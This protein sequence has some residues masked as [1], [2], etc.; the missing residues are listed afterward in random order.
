MITRNGYHEVQADHLPDDSRRILPL[1]GNDEL[2]LCVDARGMMHDFDHI[3]GSHPPPRISWS[4]RRHDR[5]YDRYNSNLFEWGFV[6]L[7]LR[8][9]TELPAVT[10]WRQQLH[11]REGYVE[12][13]IQRGDVI[14]RTISFVHL[15]TNLIVFHREYKNLPEAVNRSMNAVYTLCHVGTDDLPFRVRWTPNEPFA[16]GISADT[17]ADGMWMYRGRATLFADTDATALNVG[18]RLELEFDLP[19]TNVVTV[20]LSLVDDLGDH[21][22]ILAIPHAG[23]M[24]DA[25][26]EVHADNQRRLDS[27]TPADYVQITRE[28]LAEFA[29]AGFQGVLQSHTQAWQQW[30][31]QVKL[32]LPPDEEELRAVLDTQLYTM[33][34][35]YTQWSSPANPFNTSWGAPYFWDERFPTEGLMRL[36]IM[37][38]PTRTAEWRRAILPFSTM[39]TGGR[40]ARYVPSAVEPGSQIADR[41]ATQYYEFFTIGV[42]VNYLYEYCRQ[43]DQEDIWRRYYPIFRESAEFFR[44]WLLIELPGNNI[45]LTWLVD[46][47]ET[48][49]PVQDGPF[50]TCGAARIFQVAA[51][52]AKRLEINEAELSEWERAGAMTLRL[53]DHLCGGGSLDRESGATTADNP[54][55]VWID[56]ELSDVPAGDLDVDTEVRAWRDE[57]RKRF[58]PESQMEDGK[59]NVSGEAQHLPFWSWGPLQAAHSAAM[60]QLPEKAMDNLRKAL[61]TLMDFGA[62]NE[63]ART[64][65]TD[66]HHPWFNTAAGAY[67]RALTRMLVYARNEE[68]VLLPGIPAG[69]Q[70]FGF[71]LPVHLG[72]RVTVRVEQGVLTVLQITEAEG[73]VLDRVISLPRCYLS[74]AEEFSDVTDKRIDGAWLHLRFTSRG[75]TN[76][77]TSLRRPLDSAAASRELEENTQQC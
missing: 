56:Y 69:W 21:P 32:E 20:C 60:Q 16:N 9:E 51:E 74:A 39:M 53:A 6:D 23:W 3:W 27:W 50:A 73:R 36:G 47:N 28:V 46:V 42:I 72:G 57:Y 75:T 63:S 10:H 30:F 24:T 77:G 62:L 37:D 70:A 38:M 18:N 65:L 1:I 5:R 48:F 64:D 68:I 45:M 52:T 25:V 15:E 31:D 49:Y 34:C 71:E 55:S 13:E 43:V 54:A 44:R 12:T 22:Q 41:N 76:L 11:P 66:V 14:E 33:R 58:A 17:E 59:T 35:S 2:K 4:G 67:V 26:K 40:G 8:G 7:Q 29:D 19:A 61:T